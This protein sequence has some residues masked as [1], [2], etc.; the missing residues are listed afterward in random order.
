[1]LK[2]RVKRLSR[3]TGLLNELRQAC[4]FVSALETPL[5]PQAEPVL[6]GLNPRGIY[7][8]DQAFELVKR[9]DLA[10]A[11]SEG[12]LAEGWRQIGGAP[13]EVSAMAV[14][15][16]PTA[17]VG[18]Y[19]CGAPAHRAQECSISQ[20]MVCTSCGKTGHMEVTVGARIGAVGQS[21]RVAGVAQELGGS[22]ARLRCSCCKHKWPSWQSIL[23]N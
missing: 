18:C 9:I 21:R 2:T 12:V 19:R 5:R 16:V 4:K 1:M 13:K 3:E 20:D 11:L 7:T 8:L 22:Q 14:K 23:Q 10:R 15:V 6:W 17:T